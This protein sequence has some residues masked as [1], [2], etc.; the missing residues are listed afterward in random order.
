M[1]PELKTTLPPLAA[2][3][4]KRS[5]PPPRL[6]VPP[7]QSR[8]VPPAVTVPRGADRDTAEP[9]GDVADVPPTPR[10]PVVEKVLL[11]P[12]T[13]KRA[14]AAVEAAQRGSGRLKVGT[15]ADDH[16]RLPVGCRS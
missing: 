14:V 8:S 6:I 10:S 13:C 16:G 4:L 9:T 3:L 5:V 12:S 1:V 11:S 2:R 7:P 15:A